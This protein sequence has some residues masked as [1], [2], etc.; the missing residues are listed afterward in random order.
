MKDAPLRL[1]LFDVDG[2][3]S[4]SQEHICAAMTGAFAAA[5]LPAPEAEAIRRIVGLSLP[6][7]IARLAPEAGPEVQQTIFDAYRQAYFTQRQSAPAPLFAGAAQTLA[8]LDAGGAWL[9][10]VATGKSRR[11]LDHLL[12]YH[13]LERFFVTRQVA[14]DHPSKP[15]PAMALAAL[16]AAGVAPENGVMI[17][18]TTFDI[19]MGRAAGMRTIAVSWGYHP[20]AALEAAGP[21][22]IVNDFAALEAALAE[23]AR[24][25]AQGMMQDAGDDER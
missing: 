10:G 18:D 15:H 6:V 20:V 3:L 1:A 2:T 16:A 17:G 11:G 5:G 24:D 19:E 21:D 14:D 8:R 22:Q 12:E 13:D 9:L 25:M 7:A 23:M 4:D